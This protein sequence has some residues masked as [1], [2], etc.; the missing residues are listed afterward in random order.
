MKILL[1]CILCLTINSI[2]YAQWGNPENQMLSNSMNSFF[3]FAIKDPVPFSDP[4]SLAD[5]ELRSRI[6]DNYHDQS[7][8][9]LQYGQQQVYDRNIYEHNYRYRYDAQYRYRYLNSL[10]RVRVSR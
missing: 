3:Y 7:D 10:P 2:G 5:T 8:Y 1:C 6:S 9:M 4:Q